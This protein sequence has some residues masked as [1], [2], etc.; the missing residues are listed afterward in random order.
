MISFLN[1]SA[2]DTYINH[3]MFNPLI[4]LHHFLPLKMKFL[5]ESYVLKEKNNIKG[6]ITIAPSR[7]P[8]KRME[9][10]KLLFQENCYEEAGELIQYA[11]SKYKA[12]GTL[13]FIVK[14]DDYLP[15]LIK[16]FVTKCGFSQISYEKLWE[17][18]HIN[19]KDYKIKNYRAFRNADAPVV[20]SLYNELLLPH[21]RPLLSREPE[22]FKEFPC[23]GLSYFSEYKYVIIDPKTHYIVAC[24]CIQT[25][26]NENYVIDI[27]QS[28]WAEIDI[29]E[30]I[31]YANYQIHKRKKNFNLF[32]K[33]K[34]YTQLG[35]KQ[36]IEFI[37]KKFNC[38]QNQ[39]VL[40]NSSAGIIKNSEQTGK[41]SVL[42]QVYS[43]VRAIN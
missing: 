14:I 31:A 7:S 16:L 26:D 3:I 11:V 12:K 30:V 2:N 20:S 43:G 23:M 5:P 21:F 41:F 1:N 28:P 40:T 19:P 22:E 42:N 24:I 13:S 18:N 9:I 38:V 8:I 33:T 25:S 37:S 10:Q 17:I 36:E 27:I 6:L 15:E 29:E 34:K 32:I 39:V 4:L 35:E